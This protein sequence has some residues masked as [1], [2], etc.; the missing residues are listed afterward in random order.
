MSINLVKGKGGWQLST[1]AQRILANVNFI[2][3]PGS[4]QCRDLA[5]SVYVV[6]GADFF[7][8]V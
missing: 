2:G 3:D 7:I 8:T 5:P 4:Y 1:P 6:T